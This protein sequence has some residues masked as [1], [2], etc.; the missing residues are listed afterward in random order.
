MFIISLI[1][2]LSFGLLSILILV[3][4]IVGMWMIF[5]KMGEPGWKA[6]IP[7]YSDY[8]IFSKVWDTKFYWIYLVLTLIGGYLGNQAGDQQNTYSMLQTIV[9]VLTFVVHA[10]AL[11][12]VGR[13]FRKSTAFTLG[14]IFLETIF[15]IVLG[16]DSSQYIGNTYDGNLNLPF[17]G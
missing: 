4:Q 1:T 8:V 9:S 11:Y 3:L 17:N 5:N 2:G 15:M 7:F 12:M 10:Y 13:S 16:F 6:L 14:L